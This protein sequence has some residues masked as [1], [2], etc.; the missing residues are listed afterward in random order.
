MK[1]PSKRTYIFFDKLDKSWFAQLV[2]CV[3][4]SD[5]TKSTELSPWE[6][7]SFSLIQK[8]HRILWNPTV[9]YRF[10]KSL[11]VVPILRQ[12]NLPHTPPIRFVAYYPY[13]KKWKEVYEIN[14]LP[15]C[16]PPNVARQRLS[17]HVPAAKN[18]HSTRIV[19][20]GAF[21]AV[22]VVSYTQYV[23]D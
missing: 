15:V 13:L 21:C 11:P 23:G 8:T 5:V 20:R 7:N 3:A 16:V 19:W 10:H 18:T 6:A 2:T 9:Y 4:I 12:I 14:L 22:R 1:Q 17:K